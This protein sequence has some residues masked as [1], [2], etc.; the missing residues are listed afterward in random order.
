MQKMTLKLACLSLLTSVSITGFASVETDLAEG[1][2]A[3]DAMKNAISACPSVTTN[4]EESAIKS[5]LKA[6]VSL[7]S[8]FAAAIAAGIP[9]K[10]AASAALSSNK[11]IGEITVAALN[12][13]GVSDRSAI[14]QVIRVNN[15]V[16]GNNASIF[17][18]AS[19]AGVA[20]VTIAQA[21]KN[22]GMSEQAII[23]T[24]SAAGLNPA[25]VIAGI[26]VAQTGN[27]TAAGGAPTG[28][29]STASAVNAQ[30]RNSSAQSTGNG[31][32]SG[33]RQEELSTNIPNDIQTGQPISPN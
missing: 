30:P 4:C 25:A 5:M 11:N 1:M 22:A 2:S 23:D 7:D 32:S 13:P 31:A 12:T 28:S 27:A 14:E 24:A 21:A 26:Q 29:Q 19:N 3:T 9:I 16:K 33:L 18:A 8:T 15:A 6:G 17:K 10:A 20:Q